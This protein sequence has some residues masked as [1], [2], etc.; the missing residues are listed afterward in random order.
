MH[1]QGILL[2]AFVFEQFT[3]YLATGIAFVILFLPLDFPWN[4]V[5]GG[6]CVCMR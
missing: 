1:E 6:G 5:G 3:F 4:E 2:V